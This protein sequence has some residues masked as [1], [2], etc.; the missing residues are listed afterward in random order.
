MAR[1]RGLHEYSGDVFRSLFELQLAR[2]LKEKHKV[3]Y[4]YE[5][6]QYEYFQKV[7]NGVCQDCDGTHVSKRQWYTPD[8]ILPNGVVIEAKGYFTASDRTKL[9][10]VRAAHDSIDLRL[11]F[12]ADNKINR[13]SEMRY[14]DWCNRYKFQYAVGNI[15][16]A[17]IK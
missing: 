4:E 12:M 11:V 17:W 9:Q 16:E 3:K 13:R 1:F 14:S 8:F 2:E 10:A 7:P 5:R 15:P 6:W